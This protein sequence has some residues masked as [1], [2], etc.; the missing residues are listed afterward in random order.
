MVYEQE[1]APIQVGGVRY[2]G[3]VSGQVVLYK[4]V[5]GTI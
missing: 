3:G 1:G 2:V 4:E 5:H